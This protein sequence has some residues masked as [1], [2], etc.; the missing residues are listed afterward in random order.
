MGVVVRLPHIGV[1]LLW[2][3]ASLR[4]FNVHVTLSAALLYLPVYFAVQSLPINVNGLGAAQPVAV[5]FFAP[6]ALV[7]A[8][9]SDPVEAQ[10]A[11]VMAYSLATSGVSML[12]QFVLGAIALRVATA[13]GLKP[14][15]IEA[16][17]EVDTAA[18]AVAVE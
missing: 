17:P 3:Y 11:A 5:F 6:F 12:L 10:K 15:P 9:V 2:H 18:S 1:L 16:E 13:R 7:P 4:M 14:E 8:G